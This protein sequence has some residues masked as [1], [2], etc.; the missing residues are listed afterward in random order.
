MNPT[1]FTFTLT[2]TEGN[3]I[4]AALQE[5][6]FKHS[7]ALIQKIQAQANGQINPEPA[8]Q[9]P[10]PPFKIREVTDPTN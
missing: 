3:L 6:P 8:P 1:E 5:L 9:E 2:E 10:P 7:A 4:L